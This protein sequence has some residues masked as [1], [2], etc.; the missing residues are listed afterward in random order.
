MNLKPL[1]L[2]CILILSACQQA[3]EKPPTPT[4]QKPIEYNEDY[5]KGFWM[6]GVQQMDIDWD[7]P[8]PISLSYDEQGQRISHNH[9][10]PKTDTIL[11]DSL[12]TKPV[13]LSEQLTKYAGSSTW[14]H[15]KVS[16]KKTDPSV[17]EI[18]KLL[19]NKYWQYH[20]EILFFDAAG[21]FKNFNKKNNN[22]YNTYCYEIIKEHEMPFLIK[23]GNQSFCEGSMQYL[24]K[25][26]AISEKELQVFRW[27]KEGFKTVTYQ[28]IDKKIKGQ[29]VAFQ[30]CDPYISRNHPIHR[31]YYG[32]AKYDGGNYAIKKIIDKQYKMPAGTNKE[33][34]L[35]KVLF[36]I[37]CEGKTGLF[38]TLELDMN[39]KIK[40]FD[41]RITQQVLA[42]SQSLD[43]W[44][45]SKDPNSDM[46]LDAYKFLTY[47]IR[48]GQITEIFP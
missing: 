2:G 12:K 34:G 45:P 42:I 35:I 25:V 36:V 21:G 28:A 38:E 41:K 26:V 20:N 11:I 18:Q 48:N 33:N 15:H 3:K 14:H 44:L 39:Y 5:L 30:L 40:K 10:N 4:Q 22:E 31:Y 27:E 24:E 13:F 32:G 23:K 46:T 7:K 37:N 16:P 6:A 1:L 17:A 29:A 43:K 19:P 8:S 9:I 47:K